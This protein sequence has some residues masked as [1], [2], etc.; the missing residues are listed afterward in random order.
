[1]AR[2]NLL[3]S[4]AAASLL[5]LSGSGALLATAA[6]PAGAA[7]NNRVV[8]YVTDNGYS[9][10]NV[11]ARVGDQL[12]FVLG[13]PANNR[14]TVTWDGGRVEDELG[15]NRQWV[16][17]PMNNPGTAH[18]YDRYNV[19]GPNGQAFAGTLTVTKPGPPPP[20]TTS[21]STSTTVTTVPPT[22]ATTVPRV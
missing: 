19:S 14:H 5:V 16:A 10:T 18:F 11:T 17:Y 7:D 20:D 4:W 2:R 12:I 8:V 3:R 1:M 22:S 21:S 6:T 9:D 15:P 13:S